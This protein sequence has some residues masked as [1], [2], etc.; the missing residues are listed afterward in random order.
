MDCIFTTD[1]QKDTVGSMISSVTLHPEGKNVTVVV[2]GIRETILVLED[3]SQYILPVKG[4]LDIGLQDTMKDLLVN[5]VGA[6]TFAIVG[7]FYI[8]TKGTGK[9]AKHFIPKVLDALEEQGEA[10][11]VVK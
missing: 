3:G 4:Y 5:L 8:K 10:E 2:N 6:V 7:Y 9:V 1:M 11:L